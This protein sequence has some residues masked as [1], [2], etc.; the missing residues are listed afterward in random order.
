MTDAE[1]MHIATQAMVVAAKL[2]GPILIVALVVGLTVSLFQSVTQLQ[3]F[4]LTFVPKLIGI[5]LVLLIAGHW[6]LGVF[7]AYVQNLLG[8]VQHIIT[9]A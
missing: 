5:A 7:V 1:V 3:D 9:V 6:M 2:A 4:T 8:Q